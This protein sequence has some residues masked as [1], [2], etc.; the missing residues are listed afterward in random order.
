MRWPIPL[1]SI[2]TTTCTRNKDSMTRSSRSKRMLTGPSLE[3][4]LAYE[5]RLLDRYLLSLP[6]RYRRKIRCAIQVRLHTSDSSSGGSCRDLFTRPPA[7]SVVIGVSAAGFVSW[8]Q[9]SSS[10]GN[11]GLDPFQPSCKHD[12]DTRVMPDAIQ[13]CASNKQAPKSR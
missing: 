2:A 5:Y 11:M 4:R 7:V 12:D 8:N 13:H 3:T 9:D 10:T 6:M 1:N